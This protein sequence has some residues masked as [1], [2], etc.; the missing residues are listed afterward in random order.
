MPQMISR[1]TVLLQGAGRS[2][3]E[4][5]A[6]PNINIT[7]DVI[8][9]RDWTNEITQGGASAVSSH[10]SAGEYIDLNTNSG[11]I[12]TISITGDM[13]SAGDNINITDNVISG[14]DWTN[15]IDEH[16]NSAISSK[17]NASAIPEIVD[18][19][20]GANIGITN[21]IISGKD[22]S[23]EIGQKVDRSEF[24]SGLSAVTERMVDTV[25]ATSSELYDII[26]ATSGQG[27]GQGS[28]PWISGSKDY[29]TGAIQ[30]NFGSVIPIFSS[31]N[32]SGDHNHFIWMKGAYVRLPDGNE[33]LPFSAFS[34]YT[35]SISN[36]L[37]SNWDVTNSAYNMALYNTQNKLDNSAFSAY[38]G[39]FNGLK[40]SAVATSAEATAN[41]ILYVIS[42]GN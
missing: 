1:N 11:G 42:G 31:W 23:Y 2:N 32:L 13:Y 24:V 8:S 19:S 35:E 34:S 4:Y 27:S 26:S 21:H 15:D 6:G 33:F 38:T 30:L 22:W 40:I 37:Q 18:Y 16:I 36:T 7:N 5:S 20:A 14:K 29:G 25:S 28:C 12:T 17:A 3:I 10:L 9:G 41:D 39:D